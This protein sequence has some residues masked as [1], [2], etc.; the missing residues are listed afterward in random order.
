MDAL[1]W[2]TG[3][4]SK[5]EPNNPRYQNVTIDIERFN[6]L[7]EDDYLKIP[8]NVDFKQYGDD[9]FDEEEAL[10]DL[11]PNLDQ[12]EEKL[13]DI[14][15]EM[16]S[17]IPSKVKT[18]TEK[19]I[20]N[21][22]I[23][24]SESVKIGS[25]PLNEFT[26]EYLATLSFPTLF[27]DGKGDPTNSSIRKTIAKSDTESF[28]EKIKHLIKFSEYIDGKWVYRFAA[29]PRF[30]FWAYNMLY[31]KRLLGQG[32]FYL[33][34][35]PGEANLTIDELQEMVI[36]GSYGTIMKK[37][38]RYANITGTNAYWNKAKEELKATINQVGS[39]TIFWTLSCAE[40]H[41][42]EYHAL[43]SSEKEENSSNTLRENIINNP[44]LIDWFFTIRVENF[45]K[46]WLYETLDAEWHS[47]RFE[48][49][50][51]RG[52]IHCHGVANL[53]MTQGCVISLKRVW[54]AI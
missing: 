32:S 47:Y 2:L 11:G 17:F 41:W 54:K 27:P 33:K 12:S 48:Y 20:I 1:I 31:R 26:T 23:M 16:G 14:N 18:K 15:T 3:Q 21:D 39:P 7:P 10:P 8:M 46:H 28:S 4:D 43:F 52:S 42:P 50:V 36:A 34:Q 30:G 22:S 9:E 44:H 40:F 5:G 37:L 13:Y 51:M 53:K 6:S 45:V 25:E 49:A 19:N 24:N 38:S 35:N 29:H